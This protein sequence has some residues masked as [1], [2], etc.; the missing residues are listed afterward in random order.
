MDRSTEAR[1]FLVRYHAGNDETLPLVQFELEE[2]DGTLRL[3]RELSVETSY[4]DMVRT[5]GNRHRTF[6]SVTMGIFS[7]WSGNGIV[8]YYLAPVLTTIGITSVTN[9]TLISGLLQIWNL[10]LAVVGAVSVDRLGRRSLFLV[11]CLG[12]LTCYIVITGLAASFAK[13]H[14]SSIGVAVIPFLYIYFG[15]YDIAF[16]PLLFGYVCEIWPYTLRARGVAV[17]QVVT[18]LAV[19][20]NIFVNPIALEAIA[21][22]YYLVYVVI[23]VLITLTIYFLYPETNGHSLEEMVA[24]FDGKAADTSFSVKIDKTEGEEEQQV[25][26]V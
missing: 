11:S 6:I 23:L 4:M 16:T 24:V 18:Q 17:T 12:M 20:F 13:T 19:F 14:V 10:I 2:I 3:E 1:A 7:Q 21:W 15:F 25:E 26:K 9:Q 8:S 5:K 22:K